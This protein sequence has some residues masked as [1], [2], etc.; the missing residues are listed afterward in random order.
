MATQPA[1]ESTLLARLRDRD[2]AT[3]AAA[4]EA[5]A[6]PLF[7]TAIGMGFDQ[8]E[9][10]DLVQ[11]VFAT[12]LSTL[13]RFEGRSQLRTWLFG[14]LHHK[15]R[16]RRRALQREETIDPV[17]EHFDAL[18][19]PYGHWISPLEDLERM[20]ASKD[21]ARTLDD[22][23][24]ALPLQQREVFLLREVQELEST[25]ICNNLQITNTHL[26]VLLHRA[27][28]RLRECMKGKGWR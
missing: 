4:V 16:E 28:H 7:R 21:I 2:P 1:P 23:L 9:S 26:G 13:D 12:F 27:R 6:R 8:N 17:D 18:F 20:L 25:D 10:E 5:N 24:A 14:I 19:T 22:C 15:M 11:D 3:L